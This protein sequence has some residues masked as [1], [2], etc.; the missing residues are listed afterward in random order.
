MENYNLEYF[1]KKE[2]SFVLVKKDKILYKSKNQGLKPLVFCLRKHKKEMRGAIVF[3]KAV[4]LAAAMILAR[5]KVKEI[6]TPLVSRPAKNYLQKHKIK[7]I[8][9][10]SVENIINKNGDGLC[11]M[12]KLAKEKGLNGLREFW[13]I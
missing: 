2:F 12:E 9:K 5:G 10:K 8:Y 6:W 7:I 13:K 4:G 11:K 3:D 1:L